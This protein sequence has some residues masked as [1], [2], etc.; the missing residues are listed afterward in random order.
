[1]GSR[2]ARKI[3][4]NANAN[5][6][7]V[8]ALAAAIAMMLCCIVPMIGATQDDAAYSY[9]G[10]VTSGQN[11]VYSVD[12]GTG[13]LFVY[14]NIL[15]NLSGDA[16]NVSITG[17]AAS[18]GNTATTMSGYPDFGNGTQTNSKKLQLAF[19]TP[20]TYSYTLSAQWSKTENGNTMTQNATQTLNFT[21]A[22]GIN[23][24]ADK[25]GYAIVSTTESGTT[26]V[27]QSYSAPALAA[28]A[29]DSVAFPV[30][31][32]TAAVTK[33]INSTTTSQTSDLFTVT[34]TSSQNA[35]TIA[36]S[37]ARA[38]TSADVGSYQITVTKEYAA[39]SDSD[40]I[41]F[42]IDIF[43]D[44]AITMV[45]SRTSYS[46]YEGESDTYVSN[47]I[48]WTTN[49]A[50]DSEPLTVQDSST[51]SNGSNPIGGTV[52]GSGTSADPYK[53]SISTATSFLTGTTYW[54][55]YTKTITVSGHVD[56]ANGDAMTS[57]A[58]KDVS[59]TLYKALAFLSAPQVSNITTK[60]TSNVGTSMTLSAYIN[61]A[62]SVVFD[63]GD[64]LKTSS[65]TSDAV[66]TTYSAAHNY[67][68]S[69]LYLITI[70]AENDAGTSHTQY[71][72]N[73]YAD[74]ETPATT[75]SDTDPETPEEETKDKELKDFTL[76]IVMVVIGALA[77]LIAFRFG[78]N[79]AIVVYI[80]AGVAILGAILAG[81]QFFDVYDLSNVSNDIV[82][83]FSNLFGQKSSTE[84]TTE[85]E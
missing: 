11:Q 73:A 63:W 26:L 60:A 27:S 14:D 50:T 36:V 45:D 37:L 2:A 51:I 5:S 31:G 25:T 67:A 8:F 81:L 72:Y 52:T 49:Y 21:V 7:K 56:D 42:T 4:M 82:D 59:V 24:G 44:I 32:S 9:Y 83:F 77:L 33:T 16:T 20:G 80:A 3:K 41:T 61:G 48:R 34:D 84:T 18:T 58:T 46:V 6:K 55:T 10:D 75:P 71:L 29:T 53:V 79:Y 15:T 12:I 17:A 23:L 39:T 43:N 1:M 69:G 47:G 28:G 40:S 54:N 64:G 70:T 66:G 85:T 13:Y 62:K 38:M 76:Q 78:Y 68:K 74:E 57:T 22:Q 35:G 19:A 30:I 65:M